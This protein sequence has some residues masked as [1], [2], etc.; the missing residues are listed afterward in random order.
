[1]SKSVSRRTILRGAGVAL[2]LPLLQRDV[3][4]QAKQPEPK[5]NPMR[6]VCVANPLG[7]VAENFYP[8]KEGKLDQLSPLLAPFGKLR[9]RLSVF[10]NL[11]HGVTGGHQAVHSFLS[12]IRDNESSQWKN[13]NM[14]IDQRAAEIG[15]G[16]TRFPS[17]VA[18]VGSISGELECR[19]S[20]TRTG[21]NVPPITA[22]K[23]LFE[24]LF[25]ANNNK[26]REEK[27]VAI[28]RHA[29]ILDA[30][31]D[32]AKSLHRE[33]GKLDREKLDEYLTSVRSVEQ[34]LNISKQWL[35][36]PKPK[37]D[38]KS[39]EGGREFTFRLPLFY[40]LIRLAMVTDSTR[41]AA[42]AIPGNLP[43]Q[44]LGLQ[45]NYH[46]FSHHGKADRLLK[47]LFKIE[48]MQMQ[49]LAK[50]VK[51]LQDTELPNGDNLLDSTMVLAGSGMGN[52]SSH[53]NKNLPVML[54]GGGFRHGN[55]HVMPTEAHKRVPL[56]NLY[57]TML[58]QFGDRETEKFNRATGNMNEVLV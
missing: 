10:Q 17:I 46:A 50:F 31:N 35:D 21:V 22:L 34:R 49:Q 18:S 14:T 23:P 51:S 36:K 7:F 41:V 4:L 32:R 48:L 38:L 47:P 30:V 45:G 57:S 9:N 1:M 42:L 37:V 29:S 43:V 8:K 6:M 44:D 19:T 39:P 26:Q 58:E 20:W 5:A 53:S 27:R 28:D 55:F 2:T 12:G 54:A 11:D 33:L 56:C 15:L 13:R 52:A 3:E 16:E 25:V 24:A 40:E